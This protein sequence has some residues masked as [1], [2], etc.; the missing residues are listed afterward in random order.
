MAATIPTSQ[1]L[2]SRNCCRCRLLL[3]EAYINGYHY[4]VPVFLR[5]NVWINFSLHQNVRLEYHI[6]LH[7][8]SLRLSLSNPASPFPTCKHTPH[9]TSIPLEHSSIRSYCTHWPY[10]NTIDSIGPQEANSSNS[11]TFQSF[12]PLQQSGCPAYTPNFNPNH[13]YSLQHSTKHS[14]HS[15]LNSH[16]FF[17]PSTSATIIYMAPSLQAAIFVFTQNLPILPHSTSI[18]SSFLLRLPMPC[19]YQIFPF[20]TN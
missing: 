14:L 2:R 4:H 19:V 9:I 6:F 3:L 18:I 15:T 5:T 1:S 12:Y 20:Q 11:S 13:S 8:T 10:S 7:I 17:T 16:V